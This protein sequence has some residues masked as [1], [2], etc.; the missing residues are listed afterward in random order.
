MVR[1]IEFILNYIK[2]K[3]RKEREED[4]IKRIRREEHIRFII[5]EEEKKYLFYY[6]RIYFCTTWW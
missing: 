4:L 2:T 6:L 1:D 5:R 3:E